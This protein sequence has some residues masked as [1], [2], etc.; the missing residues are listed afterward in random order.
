MLNVSECASPEWGKNLKKVCEG[1][2]KK[3]KIYG[4]HYERLLTVRG[5]SQMKSLSFEAY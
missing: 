5:L 4:I 1:E 3:F 2:T